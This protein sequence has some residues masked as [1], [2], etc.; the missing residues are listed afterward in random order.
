MVAGKS[1]QSW[2]LSTEFWNK[3]KTLIPRYQR[4][5]NK[6][7]KRKEGGGRK[8][9][10]YRRILEGI[11][12]VLRTGCQWKA[13]PEEFGK[14]SNIHRY[15]QLWERA[16]FFEAIWAYAL[17]EYDDL[18]GIDWEWQS[19]DGCMTK[20]PLAQESVGNNPTDRGKKRYKTQLVDRRTW[21]SPSDSGVR[22][23]HA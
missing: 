12:Y 22:S 8:A 10:C 1:Y 20:A 6:E 14:G 23:Q 11:F 21:A 5:T 7:Y 13:M 2:T 9:P 16:G 3:I 19:L 17:E 4:D 18:K 15:F